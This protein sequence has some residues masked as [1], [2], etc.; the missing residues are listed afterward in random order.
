MDFMLES[1]K[2]PSQSRK[3]GET[4]KMRIT[5]FLRYRPVNSKSLVILDKE[6]RYK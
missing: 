3:L 5:G 2:P 6:N 1:F 4:A